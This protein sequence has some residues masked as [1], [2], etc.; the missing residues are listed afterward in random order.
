MPL[1]G[2]AAHVVQDD[3]SFA[4]MT[5]RQFPFDVRLA[6]AEP[7][8]GGNQLGAC[9]IGD[10]EIIGEGRGL[11]VT[12]GGQFG[13][14]EEQ[15]LGD[16]GQDQGALPGRL[17]GEQVVEAE[18][19]EGDR[20]GFGV[21]VRFTAQSADGF[22]G[23]QEDFALKGTAD[24]IDEV[25]GEVGKVGKG[26]VLDFPLVT[27]GLTH[28]VA[29]VGT[30]AV[31]AFDRGY[32]HRGSR[33]A[34]PAILRGLSHMPTSTL[35]ILIALLS[36]GCAG[37]ISSR[38]EDLHVLETK[39]R[40]RAVLGEPVNSGVEKG[41]GFE[42]YTTRRKI[43]SGMGCISYNRLSYHK[44]VRAT[45]G[46][47]ELILVPGELCLMGKRTLLGQTIRVTYDGTDHV[48][49]QYLDGELLWLPD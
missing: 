40:V 30:V 28:Q 42:E 26:A 11:P 35:K 1:V 15:S 41:Q 45:L 23:Q 25:I 43:A 47:C 39:E 46:I 31:L 19:I 7:V 2:T 34:H 14:G 10:F 12:Q 18:A 48:T 36:S 5:L 16:R 32:M 37:F 29:D 33:M 24:D 21:S 49:E 27:I 9:G 8:Q 22:V 13:A 4:E 44:T 6:L 17:T 3:A 20:D 38:G